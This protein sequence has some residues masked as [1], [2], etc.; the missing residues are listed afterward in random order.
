MKRFLSVIVAAALCL[1]IAVAAVGCGSSKTS[2][3]PAA[4]DAAAPVISRQ[5]A[6]LLLRKGEETQGLSIEAYLKDGGSLSYQWYSNETDANSGGTAVEG[7]TKSVYKPDVSAEGTAYYY[8]VVTNTNTALSGNTTAQTASAAAEVKVYSEAETPRIVE[9]PQGSSYVFGA[10]DA[11]FHLTVEAAVSKGELSYQWY[12]S[13]QGSYEDAQ[14]IEETTAAQYTPAISERGET[15]YFCEV[16]N[17]DDTASEAKTASARTKLAC[18]SIDYEY[19]SFIFEPIDDATAKLTAYNGSSLRPYIPDTDEEGRVV[20]EIGP[21]VFAG[22]SIVEV[23]I[24]DTVEK[25]GWYNAGAQFGNE[26]DG[27]FSACTSLQ[28]VNYNGHFKYLGD[29]SFNKCTALETN[30]WAMCDEI[31][32]LDRGVFQSMS[33]PEKIVF[34]ATLS[35][36]VKQYSFQSCAG[37][38]EVSFAGN[39]VTEI[40]GSAFRGV[41]T[42]EKVTVPASVTTVA[43]FLK[44]CTALK[45]VTFERSLAED[46]SITAGNPFSG[47]YPDEMVINVPEDSYNEYVSNFGSYGKYV[48]APPPKEYTLTIIGAKIDGQTSL[49][50]L[51]GET[52]PAEAQISYE[53]E[54]CLGWVYG[55]V[56]YETY[57][58]LVNGFTMGYEDSE[59]RAIYA[60][61]FTIPFTP[62]CSAENIVDANDKR[63]MEHVKVGEIMAT[64]FVTDSAVNFKVRNGKSETHGET[65]GVYNSCP[66]SKTNKT[67]LLLTFT[68]NAETSVSITYEVEYFGVIGSVNVSLE[69]GESKTVLLA[70]SKAREN[71]DVPFHQLKVTSGGE[72]G[73]DITIYGYRVV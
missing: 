58:E 14:K 11:A 59:I 44:E 64:R 57:E 15:Y 21:G 19:D 47:T 73:Y 37:I 5:P 43:D 68:N 27:V 63:T 31:E 40:K 25:L 62:S 2:Y 7:A 45:S 13:A 10:Q 69:A 56:W 30:I 22:T 33:M 1:S 61:D 66:V 50:L 70:A 20:V 17:T 46:G 32:T 16:T 49:A 29:F 72:N 67:A 48:K 36:A 52:L 9:Q 12:S 6:D 65:D 28:K 41:K 53:A 39:K 60:E 18:V 54:D 4:G 35:G 34:P 3:G 71:N 26:S 42:L 51:G 23:T 38:K 55:D 8:C 24:P